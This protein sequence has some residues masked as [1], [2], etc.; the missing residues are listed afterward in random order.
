[1]DKINKFFYINLSERTDRKE[2]IEKELE[3]LEIPQEKIFRFD[4]I[5][6]SVGAIGCA[7]S[8]FTLIKNFLES[9]DESWSIIE[10]DM[11]FLTNKEIIDIY[12]K[13]Y[14]DDNN[15]HFFNGSVTY[16]QK[17]DYSENLNKIMF[18]YTTGWYIIKKTYAHI[19]FDSLKESVIGLLQG[20]NH[21]I[22]ACD[23]VWKKYYNTHNFVTSKKLLAMQRP[24]FSDIVGALMDYRHLYTNLDNIN[25]VSPYLMGGLGN[26]M[27]MIA[28]AYAYS[29][30]T[31]SNF[32]LEDKIHCGN[33]A[34]Y[35]NNLLINLNK[36]MGNMPNSLRVSEQSFHYNVIPEE[37][38]KQHMYFYGYFQ[39]EKY[40]RDFVSEIKN[41]FK[42][43]ETLEF[44][45]EN[46]LKSMNLNKENVTV[47]LHIRRS[48]YLN[49]Q[50]FHPVQTLEYYE[51]GKKIIEDKL[52]FKPTYLYFS[53]DKFWVKENFLFGSEGSGDQI[54]ECENDYE[55]FALLQKCDHYIIANSS[56]SWW[57]SWLSSKNSN[58][59]IV[60][61]EKWFGP[62]GPQD[63]YDI[64]TEHMIKKN[65]NDYEC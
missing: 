52:G 15:A 44:Y 25:F 19:I 8:H 55:E 64:Y 39:S 5:K 57:G 13:E 30:R 29:L 53:D 49:L 46:K 59:I 28:N 27:F 2:L 54:I 31:K 18:G 65:K 42:L 40:F 9:D 51:S 33:R 24:D 41:L 32:L 10:D 14:L 4:A 34:S 61:P 62:D 58:K 47:A 1:M 6:D 50:N 37:F 43:P 63:Y 12:V 23:V 17:I 16:L 3:K 35:F 48:D 56:F 11:T 45:T 7:K 26:Q 36:Y 21:G 60:A 22:Y 20:K 38:S